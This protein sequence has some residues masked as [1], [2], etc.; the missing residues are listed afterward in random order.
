MAPTDIP[1]EQQAAFEKFKT[2]GFVNPDGSSYDPDTKIYTRAN[3]D[4]TPAHTVANVPPENAFAY[5]KEGYKPFKE[6][7]KAAVEGQKAGGQAEVKKETGTDVAHERTVVELEFLKG[8]MGANFETLMKT[9]NL[10]GQKIDGNIKF[11]KTLVFA[12]FKGDY[13]VKFKNIFGAADLNAATKL[14]NDN[15]KEEMGNKPL[16]NNEVAD[17]LADIYAV[18][19]LRAVQGAFYKKYPQ[20]AKFRD[21][22]A[23]EA[24]YDFS[25]KAEIGKNSNFAC[26]FEADKT[27][28]FEVDYKSFDEAHPQ[29]KELTSTEKNLHE[30][31]HNFRTSTVGRMLG[32]LGVISTG[33]G[34]EGETPPQKEAREDKAYEDALNGNNFIANFFIFFMG[35]GA[36]L[37]DGG[38]SIK[39]AIAGLDPKYQSLVQ[40]IQNKVPK[41]MDTMAQDP[42]YKAPA[43][44]IEAAMTEFIDKTRFAEISKDPTK[45][46]EGKTLK[47]SEPVAANGLTIVLAEGAEMI[48]PIKGHA[49]ING[50][51]EGSDEATKSFKGKLAIVGDLPKDTLFKGK[52]KFEVAGEKKKDD[53]EQKAA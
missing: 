17:F 38:A 6:A 25:Y 52:L 15:L 41:L 34:P 30:R 2:E 51:P 49:R 14:L 31:A 3:G 53:R 23:D 1:K 12:A 36:M 40:S 24:S 18:S 5:R 11:N 39:E 9:F 22:L 26:S 42:K 7:Q 16:Q 33:E 13:K 46:P 27:Q 50:N 37:Q 28:T 21:S 47:L 43:D 45:I 35:G 48:L 44:A 20:Y 10:E 29:P 19:T 8:K 32:F 4:P